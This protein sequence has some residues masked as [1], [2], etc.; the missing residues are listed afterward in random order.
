MWKRKTPE[1]GK[2]KLPFQQNDSKGPFS[3]ETFKTARLLWHCNIGFQ[4]YPEEKGGK[5]KEKKIL[6]SSR[7][8]KSKEAL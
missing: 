1:Q 5:V 3:L 2:K 7:Y 6:S 4:T 8:S